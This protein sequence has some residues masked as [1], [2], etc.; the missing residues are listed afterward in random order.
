MNES[1]LLYTAPRCLQ[2]CVETLSFCCELRE[3][4]VKFHLSTPWRHAGGTDS[5]SNHS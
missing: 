1:M 4:V 5:H 2:E 3:S